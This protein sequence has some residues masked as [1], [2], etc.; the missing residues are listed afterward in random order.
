MGAL[1]CHLHD[2]AAVNSSGPHGA[3][4]GRGGRIATLDGMRGIS[5]L[6]VLAGH[7][8]GT[9]LLP[10]TPYA[11]PVA[12]I[13]VRTF[14]VISGFLI[15][16]LLLREHT[17]RGSVS[18]R[19]FYLRRSL[20][21]FPAFY[22]YLAFV[23][24]LALASLASVTLGDLAR[25][26][27]YTSN[28]RIDRPWVLGH[29]W[30]LS[31]EEQFYLLWPLV[32]VIAGIARSTRVAVGAVLAAP[33]L[34]TIAWYRWP[35]LRGLTDQ[36]LP[37]VCDA[38]AT[39]CA[40]ALLRGTL[41][42]WRPYRAFL[43]ASWF[44]IVPIAMIATSFITRPWFDLTLGTSLGNLGVGLALH[45]GVSRPTSKVS[46][47]LDQPWLVAVG[48]LSYSLY[49]W[50]QPFMNRS[51]GA[52]FN[53]FPANIVLAFAAAKVWFTVIERPMMRVRSRVSNPTAHPPLALPL[54]PTA[55]IGVID[56]TTYSL[57]RPSM[58]E[59]VTT[60]PT[61]RRRATRSSDIGEISR[62][63]TPLEDDI[64]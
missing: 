36:A 39:G 57:P 9:G 24:I 46:R 56:L 27:T 22:C 21:I 59:L 51:G 1:A 49:L 58:H 41:E 62:E 20:R 43:D 50:Q 42:A 17:D 13:G 31:V 54:A 23:A 38:L 7:A 61:P 33:V 48:V 37:F 18:L 2:D 52:W 34:R 47:L 8:C 60:R 63:A 53:A 25:A 15:T 5:I 64:A 45:H 12:A 55:Q 6:L 30:S 35:E 28:F 10:R 26:A 16:T 19:G 4:E 29:L 32:L 11:A 3:P 40:L 14:F 44:W